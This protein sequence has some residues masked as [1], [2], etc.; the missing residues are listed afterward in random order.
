VVSVHRSILAFSGPR[1]IRAPG[2]QEF[3]QMRTSMRLSLRQ[4]PRSG[5]CQQATRPRLELLEAR[6]LL[7]V[8][9]VNST[10]DLDRAG[11]L[12]SGQESL[13]Q[14]IEDVNADTGTGPDTINFNIP[15]SGVQLIQPLSQLPT[16]TT[17]PVVIDG[18]TQPGASPNTND[19]SLGDNAV[20]MIELDGSLASQ[21]GPAASGLTLWPPTARFPAW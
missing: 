19:P 16:I 7:S 10:S 14:A 8:F 12:A 18:Y 2:F 20:L 21:S 11:G 9:V 3:H 4:R 13:R 1:S 5:R 6:T 15:G 17:H